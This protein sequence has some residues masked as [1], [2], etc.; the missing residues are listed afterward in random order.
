MSTA[1]PHLHVVPPPTDQ[2]SRMG[3]LLRLRRIA[4]QALDLAAALP[5]RAADWALRQ[6]RTAATLVLRT[7]PAGWA[8]RALR[9]S[10]TL[11]TRVGVLPVGLAAAT[12]PPIRRLL[13]RGVG[14]CLRWGADLLR[15]GW[16]ATQAL[17]TRAGTPGTAVLE[18]LQR[19]GTR[20]R[21]AGARVGGHRL[22]LATLQVARS[23]LAAVAP[24]SRMF[25][26]HRVLSLL[27]PARWIRAVLQAVVLPVVIAVAAPTALLVPTTT[28]R[29]TTPAACSTAGNADE[30]RPRDARHGV[31]SPDESIPSDPRCGRGSH[32]TDAGEVFEAS[33]SDQDAE[34][35]NRA[36]RRAMQQT[37]A[38][39]RKAATRRPGTS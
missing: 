15:R 38:R 23:A 1:T 18:T 14:T 2:L 37:Q 13:T 3:W 32:V 8:G 12:A 4:R 35:R 27:V 25:V 22:T 26:L 30:G 29:V 39:A 17:L 9:A 31:D 16:A 28:S 34:P 11:V 19:W 24:L 7:D 10:A 5:H 20:T 6:A 33:T 36:E 21:A